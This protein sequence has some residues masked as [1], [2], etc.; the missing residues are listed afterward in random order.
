[1]ALR[2]EGAAALDCFEVTLKCEE[3]EDDEEAVVVAVIPRPEPMLRVT[4]Q[5]KTP[6]P[7]TNLL[8]AGIEGCEEPKQQVSWEQEF[9]VGNSPGGSG[10]ALCMVCG[11]EI[12]FPSADTARTHILEQHPHTLDLSPS[13]KNNILEAW[14][15]GVALLQDIQADQPSLPSLESGQDGQP[16]PNSNPDPARMP[17]E[18]VV[19]LDS[20]DNPSLPKRL[21]PRG[22]RP[23]DLPVAPVT[24]PGNK[25][26]RGQ[27]WKES[28]EEEPARKK[29]S[30]HMT[31]NL[32]PDPDPPSPE[33]P[34][35][36][37]AA[38]TE[39]RHF[40]DG[41]FPPGFV[42]QLFS[43]TQLRTTDSKDSSKDSKAADGL[44]QPE[45]PS[46]GQDLAMEMGNPGSLMGFAVLG[47]LEGP[48]CTLCSHPFPAPPPGLRGTLDL[49]VIRVRM[50]EPPAVSLLQ[51]WSK[52]PQGT[53]GVGT[54]DNPDWPTVLSESSSTVKGQPEAGNG[55]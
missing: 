2:T 40:T 17:A 51:D 18:I 39:V 7:R 3:G 19:L 11:A 52:H 53:K 21:R 8:E 16:D 32:D 36:T 22:L 54:G 24:E 44:P 33:S 6:P 10:R 12:R 27:R 20:E 41:S 47:P 46:S 29:R 30:R 45:S 5:E 23:L 26:P 15:E 34:T 9:L 49:Q 48:D 37:F 50:E 43:H 42:L 28:P 4:Q 38:P 35:E 31:K 25:K 14:S 55:V 1:M 13:E